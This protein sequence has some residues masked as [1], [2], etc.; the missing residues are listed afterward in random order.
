M[1]RSIL[2]SLIAVPL[3][4]AAATLAAPAAHADPAVHDVYLEEYDAYEHHAAGENLCVPWAGQFHEVRSGVAQLL[5]PSGSRRPGEVHINF[6]V[7]GFV[8][9]IPDDA[10]FPTYSGTYREKAD[11]VLSGFTGDGDVERV[12]Q[13]RLRT[14]LEGTDGSTLTL[15]MSGK[16]TTNGTDEVVVSR[17]SFSCA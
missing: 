13:W 11:G 16:L 7:D 12:M 3:A 14:T 10:A 17:D 15:R 6:V 9:F 1:F 8:E 4:A 5:T 2:T